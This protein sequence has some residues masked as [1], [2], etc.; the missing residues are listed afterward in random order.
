[1]TMKPTVRRWDQFYVHL[2]TILRGL[3]VKY[4][5]IILIYIILK[6]LIFTIIF[7][8]RYFIY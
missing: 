4:E 7:V 1:M 3:S 8:Y 6:I 2:N 5:N